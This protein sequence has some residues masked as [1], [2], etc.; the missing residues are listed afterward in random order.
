[1]FEIVPLS[2]RN[3]FDS[4]FNPPI[5]FLQMGIDSLTHVSLISGKG[6][7]LNNY[8]GFFSYFPASIQ[9]V[10]NALISAI[11]F[12]A[13]LQCVKAIFRMYFLAKDGAQWW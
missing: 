6:I 7:S 10:L 4:I 8:L 13:V 1:M 2:V 3:L 11:I 12:L 5:S 9:A